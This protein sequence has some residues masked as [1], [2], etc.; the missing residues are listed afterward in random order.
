MWSAN[1][2]CYYLLQE[3]RLVGISSVFGSASM[4]ETV[5]NIF[6]RNQGR[7]EAKANLFI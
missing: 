7:R 4:L 1:Q 2:C 5:S 6:Y 3:E